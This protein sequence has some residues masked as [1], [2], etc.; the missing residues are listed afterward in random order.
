MDIFNMDKLPEYTRDFGT[1]KLAVIG[2]GAVGSSVVEGAI[3]M[4]IKDIVIID[5]DPL[6]SDN[7][8]KSSSL[9]RYPEDVGRNKAVALA[10]RSN[11]ILGEDTVKGINA[12]ITLF[13]PMAFARFDVICAPLDNYAAKVYVNQIWKQIPDALRPELVFGGTFGENAQSNSLDGAGP[14]LRCL[15]SEKWLEYPLVRTSC[16]GPQYRNEEMQSET[17]KTTGLASRNSANYMLEQ[18]RCRLLN[19]KAASNKRIMYKPFPEMELKV[20]TPLARKS[21]P[22]CKSY[23]PPKIILALKDCDCM[24]LTVAELFDKISSILGNEKYDVML[25][26]IEYAKVVYSALVVDD[27]C[28]ACGCRLNGLFRHEF[29]TRYADL[30]CDACRKL[31]RKASNATRTTQIG[32]KLSAI[33]PHSCHQN[34]RKKTLFELGWTIGGFIK[35]VV[36]NEECLD[37]LDK[38]Y[39]TEY[40]FYCERDK[41]LLSKLTEVE[42]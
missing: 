25:P 41:D 13:G 21:C 1:A 39:K 24:H 42:G 12:N 9:Y 14:C 26:S 15:L 33:S 6:A 34:L 31:G 5:F 10:D 3:K 8:S 37:I 32:T 20:V 28:R 30:L 4:G 22:D 18:V 16:T 38:D 19:I 40:A 17:V 7:L 29:R 36:R 11:Q 2:G 35:V 23:V 27:Y